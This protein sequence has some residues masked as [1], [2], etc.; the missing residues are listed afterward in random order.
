MEYLHLT[1][2]VVLPRIILGSFNIESKNIMHEMIKTAI[3]EG[4]TGFDTSPSYGNEQ[5][6]GDA[7]Q[8]VQVKKAR[9][10]YFR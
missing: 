3:L 2:G 10:I 4:E 6:L 7:L 5:I 8:K 1:N 9:F